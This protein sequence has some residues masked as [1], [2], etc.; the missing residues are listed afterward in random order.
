MRH[1]PPSGVCRAALLGLLTAAGLG[2]HLSPRAMAGEPRAKSPPHDA[3]PTGMP[4]TAT[5]PSVAEPAPPV[6]EIV[7]NL[8]RSSRR[9]AAPLS[10]SPRQTG[11]ADFPHPAYPRIVSFRRAQGL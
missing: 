4:A 10:L 3:N 11:R 7:P 5:Q 2:W 1:I 9:G 6:E 8:Q